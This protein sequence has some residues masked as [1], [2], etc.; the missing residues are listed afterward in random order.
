MV[1]KVVLAGRKLIK[2]VAA[3]P[4]TAYQQYVVNSIPRSSSAHAASRPSRAASDY[5]GPLMTQQ[6]PPQQMPPQQQALPHQQ[7]HW[8]QQ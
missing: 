5:L 2:A 3:Q 6:A 4:N 1:N 7:H 8:L